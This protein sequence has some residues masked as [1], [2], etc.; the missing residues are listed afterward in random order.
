MSPS[1]DELRIVTHALNAC[2]HSGLYVLLLFC[3]SFGLLMGLA[4]ERH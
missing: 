3:R 1:G 2:P 4:S